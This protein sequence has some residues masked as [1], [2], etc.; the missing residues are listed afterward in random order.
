VAWWRRFF[1]DNLK[2]VHTEKKRDTAEAARV[3]RANKKMRTG[4]DDLSGIVSV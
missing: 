3:W 1:S 4:G 2:F